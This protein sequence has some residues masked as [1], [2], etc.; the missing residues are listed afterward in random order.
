[1][2]DLSLSTAYRKDAVSNYHLYS[3]MNR[4]LTSDIHKKN[5]NDRRSMHAEYAINNLPKSG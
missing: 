5:H 2:L 3:P 1:M 4:L